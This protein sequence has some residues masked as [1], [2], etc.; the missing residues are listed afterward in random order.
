M[1][2]LGCLLI[3]WLL[4]SDPAPT[5]AA[6]HPPWHG[7]VRVRS[8]ASSLTH[9]LNHQGRQAQLTGISLEFLFDFLKVKTAIP[10]T[11]RIGDVNIT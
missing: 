11:I 9:Q 8:R 7:Q 6:L 5:G 2:E 4:D 1:P 3:I 10:H